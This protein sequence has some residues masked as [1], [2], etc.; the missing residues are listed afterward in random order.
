MKRIIAIALFATAALATS[1][2]AFAQQP[3]MK[4]KIPFDFTVGNTWLPAGEYTI[5]SP[6]QSVIRVRN[7]DNSSAATVVSSHSNYEAGSGSKLV[8]L[9]Y[10]DRYF[11]HRVLCSS[12]SA[13]NLDIAPGKAEKE[14]HTQEAKLHTS[15][16]VLVAA[17]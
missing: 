14:A 12:N 13:M 10:G 5:Y 6:L 8:F 3:G 7:A 1:T 4:A 2:G 15:K 9:R 17:R 16:E 11:L